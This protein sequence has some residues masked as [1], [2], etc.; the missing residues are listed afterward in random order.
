M[1][2]TDQSALATSTL[3]PSLRLTAHDDGLDGMVSP[4]SFEALLQGQMVNCRRRSQPLGL[5]WVALERPSSPHPA[6]VPLFEQQGMDDLGRRIRRRVRATDL[7]ARTGSHSFAVILPG[8]TEAVGQQVIRRLRLALNEP[9][10]IGAIRLALATRLGQAQYPDD[11]TAAAE[12][13]ARA[14]QNLSG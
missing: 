6:A 8:A 9:Y 12:L 7:A 3:A 5:I 10:Q 11:S 2:P 14:R 4:A 13:V 1:P